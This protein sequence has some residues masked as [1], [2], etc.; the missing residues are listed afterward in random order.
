MYMWPINSRMTLKSTDD[1]RVDY[2]LNQILRF[3]G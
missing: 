2:I 1:T 3:S